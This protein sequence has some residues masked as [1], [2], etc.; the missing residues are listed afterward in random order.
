MENNCRI[1]TEPAQ[2]DIFNNELMFEQKKSVKIYIVLNNFLYEKVKN[3]KI[4]QKLAQN[5][6]F[7]SMHLT[8]FLRIFVKSVVR[9][10][11]TRILL[12]KP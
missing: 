2:Y 6:I 12:W 1:C 10:S 4:F 7:S 3:I 9:I 5:L 8:T 11:T